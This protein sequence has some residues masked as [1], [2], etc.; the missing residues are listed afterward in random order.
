MPSLP[1]LH[2]I[3][4]EVRQL[5]L[6]CE[7][8][9]NRG[10]EGRA[11]IYNKCTVQVPFM[12]RPV[13]AEGAEG[14][15]TTSEGMATGAQEA[16]PVA[17]KTMSTPSGDIGEGGLDEESDPD[18]SDFDNGMTNFT[19]SYESLFLGPGFSDFFSAGYSSILVRK[20]Y[21]DMSKHIIELC[22]NGER[23]VVVTGTPGIGENV[24]EPSPDNL[25]IISIY[26]KIDVSLFP[27][28]RKNPRWTT[29]GVPVESHQS[30]IDAQPSR[31]ADLSGKYPFGSPRISWNLGV[32]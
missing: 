3:D 9:W 22:K 12:V 27:A 1:L 19:V 31:R 13:G 20:E 25:S 18:D 8:Y 7:R 14:A 24:V 21:R 15:A 29:H 6:L 17:P 10:Q 2:L 11:E 30:Y 32:G 28:R 16:I 23:G 4:T 26:R 5:R